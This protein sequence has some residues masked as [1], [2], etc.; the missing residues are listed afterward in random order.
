[1]QVVLGKR[2][3]PEEVAEMSRLFN[4]WISA[5]LT[6][7]PFNLPFL[8]FGKALTARKVGAVCPHMCRKTDTASPPPPPQ[9]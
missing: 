1:M 3:S 5:M 9:K 8:P 7:L 6:L 2:Y 4:T